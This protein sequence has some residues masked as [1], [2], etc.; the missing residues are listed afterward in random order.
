MS[1]Q[2]RLCAAF[3]RRAGSRPDDPFAMLVSAGAEHVL[4]NRWVLARSLAIGERLQR[5]GRSVGDLV[6]IVLE[7]GVDLYPAFVGCMIQ[8]FV[9]SFMPPL[10]A[11]QDPVIFRHSKAASCSYWVASTIS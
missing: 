6:M 5:L 10:T 11:K 9:P 7:H 4:T 2:I 3:L 8:G 1:G